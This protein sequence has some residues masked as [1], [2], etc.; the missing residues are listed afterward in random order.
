M[1]GFWSMDNIFRWQKVSDLLIAA[2]YFSIPLEILYFVAGLR[3]LLPFRWVLVQFGAFIV[4]CGLTHL[5]AAF[6]YEPHPFVLVLLLTVAKFLTALVSFLTAITPLRLRLRLI[7]KQ[8][9]CSASRSASA[10]SGSKPA[11]STS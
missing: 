10:C 5:L 11:S 8:R 7:P 2:A 6:T 1:G 9:S 4:L 3:H